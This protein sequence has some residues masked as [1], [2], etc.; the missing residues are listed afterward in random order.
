[1]TIRNQ[2]DLS[3]DSIGVL[4]DK[5]YDHATVL[6][7]VKEHR[8]DTETKFKPYLEFSTRNM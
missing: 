8:N 7:H 2:T 6:N 3:Y 1:M 4:I 5:G